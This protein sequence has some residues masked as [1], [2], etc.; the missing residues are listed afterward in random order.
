MRHTKRV[1]PKSNAL[2]EQ[3]AL[4]RRPERVADQLFRQSDFFDPKDL[5]QV[6]YEMLRQVQQGGVAV[7]RAAEAFGFSRPSFY[8][9]QAAFAAAGLP[10]LL[11]KKRGPRTAHKLNAEV[12]RFIHEVRG[13]DPSATASALVPLVRERFGI[14][15]HQR[16]VERALVR[17]EKK[18]L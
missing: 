10:G 2:R 11:P 12:M 8:D 18:R 16:S 5:P 3:G 9:A 14:E 1:D 15:V 6:K 7:T 13:K 17:Q 4:N